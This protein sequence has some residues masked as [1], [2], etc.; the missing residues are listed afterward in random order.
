MLRTTIP[1]EISARQIAPPR[2]PP[3]PVTSTRMV[4]GLPAAFHCAFDGSTHIGRA[5]GD[6]YASRFQR[7]NLL[8]RGTFAAGNDGPG[9]THA[10]AGRRGLPGNEC[11]D[12]LF[13]VIANE[14]GGLDFGVA[15]DF[16]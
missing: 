1:R 8:R 11:G 3:P 5:F 13:D 2:N 7:V 6:D 9:V 15:A 12:R 10:L 16:T 14:L 4:K